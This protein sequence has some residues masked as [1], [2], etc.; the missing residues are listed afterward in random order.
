MAADARHQH[1]T[2][3]GSIEQSQRLR[4]D[5][6][7]DDRAIAREPTRIFGIGNRCRRQNYS[8][9]CALDTQGP[10]TI[11]A[12]SPIASSPQK[13]GATR[14]PRV[15]QTARIGR[16]VARIREGASLGNCR[17]AST[18]PAARRQVRGRKSGAR[19]GRP[20][21]PGSPATPQLPSNNRCP[22][23][24]LAHLPAALS[25]PSAAMA[26]TSQLPPTA[27]RRSPPC[28]TFSVRQVLS[29]LFADALADGMMP[30]L[31]TPA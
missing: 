20:S 2:T 21:G 25:W 26:A 4:V 29:C 8:P 17:F 28:R 11:R 18:E 6:Q 16:I 1:R 27:A 19:Q 5:R 10:D 22:A 12:P 31:V 14:P 9:H 24:R 3:A 15:R 30:A 7:D 23:P 13:G